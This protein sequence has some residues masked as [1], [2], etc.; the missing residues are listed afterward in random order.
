MTPEE[1]YQRWGIIMTQEVIDELLAWDES[2]SSIKIEMKV[3]YYDKDLYEKL[4]RE[5]N[6]KIITMKVDAKERMAAYRQAL[7]DY[8]MPRPDFIV[9]ESKNGTNT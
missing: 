2:L 7:E 3:E 9:E 4:L 5:A 6:S 1:V 8:N